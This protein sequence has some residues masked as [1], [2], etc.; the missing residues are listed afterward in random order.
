MNAYK[1]VLGRKRTK[2]V[3]LS[4]I[5]GFL[6]LRFAIQLDRWSNDQA[7]FYNEA[8]VA[9]QHGDMEQAVQLFGKSQSAYQDARHRQKDWLSQL[10]YPMPDSGLAAQA[11]FQMAKIFLQSGEIPRA[12]QAF[13][14]SL[15]FNP[16]NGYD[17]LD[18]QKAEQLH[19][20]AM[21]VK[22]DLEQLYKQNQ[23][24]MQ[25]PSEGNGPPA[26][27]DP[28]SS[29]RDPSNNPGQPNSS[30]APGQPGGSSSGDNQG[31]DM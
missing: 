23:S 16:G 31:G 21:I 13:N 5:L 2:W 25:Q 1:R 29:G 4:L 10:I 19:Q 30:G 3:L 27:G 8:M 20:A 17:S 11:S 26:D 9:Y 12:V 28:Q 18:P 24:Q 6:L 14:Q 15:Q 22:Y 7:F